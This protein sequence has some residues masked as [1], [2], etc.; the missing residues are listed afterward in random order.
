MLSIQE[1]KQEILNDGLN[2]NLDIIF[3]DFEYEKSNNDLENFDELK[4][5]MEKRDM[6]AYDSA[7]Y[8]MGYIFAISSTY[9]AFIYYLE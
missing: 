2:E 3:D 5:I 1:H 9:E 6:D 7:N 8:D 4:R